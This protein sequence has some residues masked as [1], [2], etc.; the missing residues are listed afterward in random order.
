LYFDLAY[1]KDPAEPGYYWGGF[2]DTRKA[3]ELTPFDIRKSVGTDL[4]GE[5]LDKQKLF[6]NIRHL[7]PEGRANIRGIQGLLWTENSKGA[8]LLEYQVF[9]KL[10]GLAER[11]WAAQ[12]QWAQIEEDSK[13]KKKLDHAWNIFAN[14]LGQK[15]LPRLDYINGGV[16]YRLPLPGAVIQDGKLKAN[17]SFPGL[18]IRYTLDGSEPTSQS[19]VYNAP[20][21]LPKGIKIIKL[22]TFSARHSSRVA[23]VIHR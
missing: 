12:P 6:D 14:L 1:T 3:F 21:T 23:T 7:T 10:I 17:V 16:N 4:M 5:S 13:R 19:A 9:P 18:I 15:E 22:K 2:V 11:A 20:V 8:E